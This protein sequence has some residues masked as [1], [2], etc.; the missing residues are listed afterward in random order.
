M[1]KLS[2]FLEKIGLCVDYTDPYS[3]VFNPVSAANFCKM[4]EK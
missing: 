2:L 1:L 4:Q 3:K